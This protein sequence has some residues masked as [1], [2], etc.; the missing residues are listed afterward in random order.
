MQVGAGEGAPTSHVAVTRLDAVLFQWKPTSSINPNKRWFW[1][2]EGAG[3]AG[4]VH[5]GGSGQ[6]GGPADGGTGVRA[7]R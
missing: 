4:S 6:P 7:L 5:R 1:R 3:L 2:P